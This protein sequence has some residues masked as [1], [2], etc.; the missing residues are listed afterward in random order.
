M[1]L[2]VKAWPDRDS[3]AGDTMIVLLEW[4]PVFISALI[5]YGLF[6][7]LLLMVFIA[8]IV[9]FISLFCVMFDLHPGQWLAK[10]LVRM[11]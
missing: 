6:T 5:I 10:W 3:D 1:R 2:P 8:A 7:D 11:F 9:W 4:L